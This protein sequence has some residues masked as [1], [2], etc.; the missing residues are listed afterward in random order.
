VTEPHFLLDTNICIYL[1]G[2][3][4]RAAL[5]RVQAL[6]PGEVVTSAVAYAEVMIGAR[7]RQ[8]ESPAEALFAR[9]PVLPFDRAAA[10]VYAHLP[11]KR[12]RYD[13]LIAAHA[14]ALGVTLVTNDEADFADLTGLRVENWT[15]T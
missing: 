14:L 1:L 15:R 10:L 4:S 6:A 11:F 8:A 7:A 9:I 5:D 3:H 2:G 12:A 13:R